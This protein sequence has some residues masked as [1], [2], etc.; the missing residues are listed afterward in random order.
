MIVQCNQLVLDGF[1]MAARKKIRFFVHIY[2]HAQNSL[3]IPDLYIHS[4]YNHVIWEIKTV[5]FSFKFQ[6]SYLETNRLGGRTHFSMRTPGFSMSDLVCEICPS[7]FTLCAINL[8]QIS[9]DLLKQL[10][11]ST[12]RYLTLTEIRSEQ[13]QNVSL[14]FGWLEL[15]EVLVN[16]YATYN[17][18][19]GINLIFR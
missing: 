11:L 5:T 1:V 6:L 12:F 4:T 7:L 3:G 13:G 2:L 8:E 19:P 15:L 14:C 9:V 16:G 18:H 17:K 10:P